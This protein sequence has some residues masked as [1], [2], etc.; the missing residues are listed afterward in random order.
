MTTLLIIVELV[1]LY[2]VIKGIYNS[3]SRWAAFG[4]AALGF[5]IPF[6]LGA[7]AA[8]LFVPR[9]GTVMETDSVLVNIGTGISLASPIGAVLGTMKT[10]SRKKPQA[11]RLSRP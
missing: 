8:Y 4:Y 2:L 9:S 6:A 1:C 10:K 5:A 11:L 7:L 3:Q